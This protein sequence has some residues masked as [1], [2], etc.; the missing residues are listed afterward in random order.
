M[1]DII[2]LMKIGAKPIKV[3][4]IQVYAPISEADEKDLNAFYQE[5]EDTILTILLREVL[6]FTKLQRHGWF[7]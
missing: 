6:F 4:S 2:I 5:I 3:N 1:S 7:N